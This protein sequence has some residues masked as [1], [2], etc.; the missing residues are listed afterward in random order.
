MTRKIVCL[1]GS[2]KF[3]GAFEEANKRETLN[4]TIVLT[5]G[6]FGHCESISISP[7]EKTKLDELHLDKLKL[8]DE[9]LFLNVGGYLGES[10]LREL[11]FCIAND[12]HFRFIEPENLSEE[13]IKVLSSKVSL[14]KSKDLEGLI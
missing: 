5:V 10:S 14:F 12:I 11:A 8:A 7:E 3:K 2:T 1:C 6:W 4:G 9:A 13:T